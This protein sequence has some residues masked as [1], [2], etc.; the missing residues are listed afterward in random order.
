MGVEMLFLFSSDPTIEVSRVYVVMVAVCDVWGWGGGGVECIV[1]G[2]V[3]LFYVGS[4][5]FGIRAKVHPCD[6]DMWNEFSCAE[7]PCRGLEGVLTVVDF[8]GNCEGFCLDG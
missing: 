4:W 3:E 7:R 8:L 2:G 1:K 6:M 5:N